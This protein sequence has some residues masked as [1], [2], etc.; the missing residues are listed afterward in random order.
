MRTHLLLAGPV[1]PEPWDSLVDAVSDEGSVGGGAGATVSLSDVS[2]RFSLRVRS[3]TVMSPWLRISYMYKSYRYTL[4]YCTFN[5]N[6]RHRFTPS[7]QDMELKKLKAELI[8][9]KVSP[10]KM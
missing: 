10:P 6:R 2:D 3:T 4:I 5:I 1:A 8:I 7:R 9:L